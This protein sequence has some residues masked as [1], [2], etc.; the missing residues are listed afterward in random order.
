MT[1][2]EFTR[3]LLVGVC[4]YVLMIFVLRISG[5]RTLSKMNAFDFVVTVALGSTVSSLLINNQTNL[6]QGVTTF[7]LLIGLQFISTW[8][9]VRSE[10]VSNLLKSK[11]ALIYYDNQYDNRQMKK[12]RISKAEILQAV[13]SQGV[14][15]MESISAVILETDGKISVLKKNSKDTVKDTLSNV[16]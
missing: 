15:S 1:L 9:S 4:F 5:K 6:W 13:R 7:F 16:K 3:L 10:T 11:P 8:L 2:E 14:D 12:E